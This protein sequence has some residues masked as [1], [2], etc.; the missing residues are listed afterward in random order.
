[1]PTT[2]QLIFDK[3]ESDLSVWNQW[4]LSTEE[5]ELTSIYKEP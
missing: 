2:T 3:N 1:M 4:L 5:N